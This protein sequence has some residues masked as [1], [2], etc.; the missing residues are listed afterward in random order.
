MSPAAITH[1]K[2]SIVRMMVL[3][4]GIVFPCLGTN[5]EAHAS[6]IEQKLH[7]EENL[8]RKATQILSQHLNPGEYLIYISIMYDNDKI[9][10]DLLRQGNKINRQKIT[11]PDVRIRLPLLPFDIN[12]KDILTLF[13]GEKKV[14]L[15]FEPELKELLD[16]TS[17]I[18]RI[19]V[20]LTFDETLEE[21][22]TNLIIPAIKSV[23]QY[24]QRRDQFVVETQKLVRISNKQVNEE[25]LRKKKMALMNAQ[26]SEMEQKFSDKKENK[27]GLRGMLAGIQVPAASI[28]LSVTFIFIALILFIAFSRNTGKVVSAFNAF[29]AVYLQGKEKEAE[30]IEASGG[31]GNGG[32]QQPTGDSQGDQ[33]GQ[34]QTAVRA[35]AQ[36]AP[37]LDESAQ[38]ERE[39]VLNKIKDTGKNHPYL[40]VKHLKDYF[41]D[42]K[43]IVKVAAVME[44]VGPELYKLLMGYFAPSDAKK[45]GSFLQKDGAIDDAKRIQ[46]EACNDLYGKLIA[47]ELLAP[48]F[49]EA[50]NPSFLSEYTDSE[51]ALAL[52]DRTPEEIVQIFSIITPDRAAVIYQR[53]ED[54]KIAVG[55]ALKHIGRIEKDVL[56]P[57]LIYLREH[58]ETIEEDDSQSFDPSIFLANMLR[59]LPPEDETSLVNTLANEKQLLA[60]VKENYISYNDLI[61]LDEEIIRMII[62]PLP[63]KQIA[64]LL[65]DTNESLGEIIKAILPEKVRL[66]ALDELEVIQRSLFQKKRAIVEATRLK[67]TIVRSMINL[68]N[69]GFIDIADFTGDSGDDTTGSIPNRSTSSAARPSGSPPPIPPLGAGPTTTPPPSTPPFPGNKDDKGAA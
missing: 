35:T 42:K 53:L 34:S 55:N 46:F 7:F 39:S 5:T 40:I 28:F 60:S 6:I 48:D 63:P 25:E 61:K 30:A 58:L 16:I 36:N 57:I 56:Q 10:A 13:E 23:I 8:E 45:L 14:E 68:L 18:K 65:V 37:M 62:S 50:L 67:E 33:S 12:Q 24:N 43:A 38:K 3:I 32:M 19:T 20:N 64:N 49:L 41:N 54:K 44:S 29:G 22:T 4:C 26:L 1:A 69:D 51:L 27:D 15:D 66:I 52:K 9:R 17:Y 2:L 31:G 11:E 59:S 47:E 21:A